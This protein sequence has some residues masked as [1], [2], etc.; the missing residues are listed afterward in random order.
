MTERA[1]SYARDPHAASAVVRLPNGHHQTAWLFSDMGYLLTASHALESL[2]FRVGDAIDIEFFAGNAVKATIEEMLYRK[3][4]LI[5]YCIIRAPTSAHINIRPIE[6]DINWQGY[7]GAEFILSGVR[8]RTKNIATTLKGRIAQAPAFRVD[9]KRPTAI[10]LDIQEEDIGGMSG[11][12]ICVGGK[13]PKAIAIQSWQPSQMKTF[14][15][16]TPIG[17]LLEHS[18]I[19]RE[20]NEERVAKSAQILDFEPADFAHYS[21]YKME[22][23]DRG[24]LFFISLT[25]NCEFSSSV[26]EQVYSRWN[27]LEERIDRTASSLRWFLNPTKIL[28]PFQTMQEFISLTDTKGTPIQNI[29]QE[30]IDKERCYRLFRV[31]VDLGDAVVVDNACDVPER[32]EVSHVLGVSCGK[33]TDRIVAHVGFDLHLELSTREPVV[34]AKQILLCIEDMLID[35]IVFNSIGVLSHLFSG[36]E[37]RRE[38][39]LLKLKF[40]TESEV[41]PFGLALPKS[42]IS[43]ISLASCCRSSLSDESRD[44]ER[45]FHLWRLLVHGFILRRFGRNL[46]D[47]AVPALTIEELRFRILGMKTI[48]LQIPFRKIENQLS[49]G[50]YLQGELLCLA[51]VNRRPNKT[52]LRRELASYF[53][54]SQFH[55]GMVN[56]FRIE[57]LSQVRKYRD[58]IQTFFFR[59]N[60]PS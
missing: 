40:A 22:Y 59:L 14:A 28:R 39:S 34:A 54:Y 57:V 44:L 49:S 20:F 60:L 17:R 53:G 26:Y 10:Q 9:G 48:G 19:L 56:V 16:A 24:T 29:L 12:A 35:A 38:F 30:S 52:S 47:P 6:V 4:D 51:R 21:K 43:Y 15:V 3:A 36:V 13:N 50:R 58:C 18:K 1:K 2:S 32:P 27:K 5:D 7:G 31:Y 55:V 42:G 8:S 33:K 46:T 23:P 37:G 11:A 25:K 41:I 45:Y